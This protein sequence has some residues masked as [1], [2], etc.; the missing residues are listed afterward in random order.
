MRHAHIIWDP[1]IRIS[2]WTVATAFL[3]NA[4]VIEEG[5]EVHELVGYYV[6]VALAVRILW[7]FVGSKNARFKSFIPT[8]T[9]VKAHIQALIAGRIPEEDGHNPLGAL[10][11][12]ALLLGLALTGLSGWSIV[13][14]F[15]GQHWVEEVHGVFANTTLVLAFLHMAAVVFFSFK[16]PRNLIRQMI[17][18]RV[19][20]R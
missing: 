4:L 3:L 5:S 1:I 2:H 12:F 9:G 13:A 7:G 19:E 18:G 17:T 10:M 6:L 15:G 16:G 8:A 14:V 11:I 20:R